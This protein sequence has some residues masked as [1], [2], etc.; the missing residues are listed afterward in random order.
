MAP[1]RTWPVA[2]AAVALLLGGSVAQP[3]ALLAAAQTVPGA[4]NG[5]L[6]P[7]DAGR[8]WPAAMNTADGFLRSSSRQIGE[9][10]ANALSVQSSLDDMRQDLNAEYGRWQQKQKA[11][12]ADR[13]RMAKEKVELEA[14]LLQ[15]KS[16]S[17]EKV[18]L[19]GE[20][21]M[22]RAE[23]AKA[24][25]ETSSAAQRWE[26]QNQTLQ[27]DVA[28]LEQQIKVS[29]IL[30]LRNENTGTQHT[31]E[32]QAR[33]AAVQQDIFHLNQQVFNLKDMLSHQTVLTKED[34]SGLLNQVETL[35]KNI[36]SLQD[37][38]VARAQV[39]LEIERH[40]KRLSLQAAE[41]VKQKENLEETRKNCESDLMAI[42]KKIQGA[43]ADL[44]VANT[45]M[46]QCQALDAQTQQL[47]GQV[48]ECRALTR[49]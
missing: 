21:N 22:H 8:V 14:Q 2:R 32:L 24:I 33:N 26:L 39:Q 44:K 48:N 41:V 47:Q 38:V 42:D 35:Q 7:T 1:P 49:R 28:L 15:E 34:H 25:T 6:A 10:A 11:L 31:T 4:G 12:M 36:H 29:T 20:L 3:A 37:E 13:D 30:R 46:R 23:T 27:K 9:A 5:E 45:E 19:E 18:R 16:L 43:Q 17:E 40:W